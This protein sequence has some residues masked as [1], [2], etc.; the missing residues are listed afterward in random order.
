M[1]ENPDKV[2]Y[3]LNHS[4]KISYPEETIIKYLNLYNIKGWI[5]QMQFSIYKLDF[6]FPEYKL[7]VEIDGA[8]H[9]TDKVKKI[10]NR[11]DL[12]SYI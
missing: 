12:D 7:D 9:N 11:R 2:P 4:S 8:T 5:F 10:D 3:L 6:A 1:K